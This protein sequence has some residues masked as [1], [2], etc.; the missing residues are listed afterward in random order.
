MKNTLKKMFS[1]TLVVVLLL[2]ALPMNAM[3]DSS[4]IWLVADVEAVKTELVNTT[5]R[6]HVFKN[7]NMNPNSC[8]DYTI[9]T[10]AKDAGVVTYKMVDSFL[11]TKYTALDTNKNMTLDGLYDVTGNWAGNYVT[12]N[13]TDKIDYVQYRLNNVG[14]I[15]INVMLNN[16]KLKS[17][18]TADSSN[19]KTGDTIF[20]PVMVMGLTASALVAAYVIGK[21]RFAR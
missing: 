3:A 4:D 15:D 13:K 14:S 12:N 10:M 5:V 2:C 11:R 9:T 20:V 18:S 8:D 6:L 19:P 21:K 17:A 16:A 7:L 1:L